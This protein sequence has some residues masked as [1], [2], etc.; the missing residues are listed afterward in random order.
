[1]MEKSSE[2]HVQNCNAYRAAVQHGMDEMEDHLNLF[3]LDHS[4]LDTHV[5]KFS[6]AAHE[7]SSCVFGARCSKA[8]ELSQGQ[9]QNKRCFDLSYR[10]CRFRR[11]GCQSLHAHEEVAR[12]RPQPV[13]L[14]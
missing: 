1:M 10:C 3:S 7:E 8:V 13:V 5:Q 14:T 2:A 12:A 4:I 6:L 9:W 11:Q